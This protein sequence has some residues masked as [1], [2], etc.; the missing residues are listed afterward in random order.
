MEVAAGRAVT[1]PFRSV[2]E[3]LGVNEG[4][5]LGYFV[6]RLVGPIVRFPVILLVVGPT[7][8]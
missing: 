6:I 8:G 1:V 3:V 7:G 4:V 5:A 2:V